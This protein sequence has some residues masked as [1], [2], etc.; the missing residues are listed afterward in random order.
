MELLGEEPRA[1][2]GGPLKEELR[3]ERVE[4]LG[5]EPT[6]GGLLK[7]ELRVERVELLGEEPEADEGDR[8]KRNY[9]LKE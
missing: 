3:V 6:E 7:E 9:E 1:N 8:S 5:E 2:G 4:V